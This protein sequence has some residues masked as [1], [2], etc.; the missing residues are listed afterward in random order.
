VRAS[1]TLSEPIYATPRVR[2]SVIREARLVL[3][4]YAAAL[5]LSIA[6][7][8]TVLLWYW[9]IPALL[10]QPMLRFYLLAEHSGCPRTPDMLENSRTT[11]TNALVRFLAWNMPFHAEHHAWPSIPFHAL[12]ATNELIG[13]KLRK[14]APGYVAALGEIWRTM[15]AGQAL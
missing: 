8:S 13:G 4:I 15:R 11:Y 10:G 1:G 2:A 5:G 6:A 12:P 7:Q 9:V 14:T 3:A